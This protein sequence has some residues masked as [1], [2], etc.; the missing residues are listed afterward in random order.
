VKA[1]TKVR[2]AS[3]DRESFKRIFGDMEEMLKKNEER[4]KVP[5]Q[6]GICA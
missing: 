3:I 6:E 2:L 4:Y 1:Q 5:E